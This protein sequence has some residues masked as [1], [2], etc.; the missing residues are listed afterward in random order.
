MHTSSFSCGVVGPE[1]SQAL[2]LLP[3]D[4]TSLSG[5]SSLL[6]SP[7]GVI[8]NNPASLTHGGIGII[9]LMGNS[10]PP[11]HQV[12]DFVGSHYSGHM[13]IKVSP[14]SQGSE[15]S[16]LGDFLPASE[17]FGFVSLLR[18]YVSWFSCSLLFV[19]EDLAQ[20]T[21]GGAGGAH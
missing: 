8:R 2:A 15:K 6:C 21:R 16:C 10:S 13:F 19:T 1:D 17:G 4:R 18:Y 14:R 7:R 3:G 12:M 9:S 5:I 20:R 11:L